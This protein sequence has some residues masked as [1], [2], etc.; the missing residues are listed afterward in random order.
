VDSVAQDLAGEGLVVLAVNV[1]ESK[2][3]VKRYLQESPR[4]FKIALTEDTNLAAAFAARGFPFYVL[5]DREGRIAATQRGSG[6]EQASY[7]LLGKVG[8]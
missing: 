2:R 4:S 6:G 5:I 1:G 3:K 7:R 8:Q